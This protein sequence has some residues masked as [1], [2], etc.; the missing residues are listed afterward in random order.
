MESV[1]QSFESR[2]SYDALSSDKGFTLLKQDSSFSFK[3]W[4]L[5]EGDVLRSCL[6]PISITTSKSVI[7]DCNKLLK[8]LSQHFSSTR[9][10]ILNDNSQVKAFTSYYKSAVNKAK[11]QI[12]INRN[13]VKRRCTQ[14]IRTRIESMAAWRLLWSLYHLDDVNKSFR[15]YR[16]S[17]HLSSNLTRSNLTVDYAFLTKFPPLPTDPDE[18]TADDELSS[19]ISDGRNLPVSRCINTL[20]CA[21]QLQ[22][23]FGSEFTP[24]GYCTQMNQ[25][26]LT[27]I[28]SL[29]T[30]ICD[31]D[32]TLEGLYHVGLIAN[33]LDPI[34]SLLA[35][36][37]SKLHI[38][39]HCCINKQRVQSIPQNQLLSEGQKL[40]LKLGTLP[41]TFLNPLESLDLSFSHS[42]SSPDIFF[43][44]CQRRLVH[45][46][47]LVSVKPRSS[48]HEAIGLE[49]FVATGNSQ[50]A[51]G[52]GKFDS[53]FFI[54]E[55]ERSR[56][57]V[58]NALK[59]SHNFSEKSSN[60]TSAREF[61]AAS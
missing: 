56:D 26:V 61:F 60:F 30:F 23:L 33:T 58:A 22:S 49:L 11:A 55:N 21:C 14:L 10:S 16:Q 48:A 53:V 59:P 28:S 50:I 18:L 52:V 39:A 20:S 12:S 44:L 29:S 17:R 7:D 51:G 19:V 2:H 25:V 41:P 13:L 24:R 34:P 40:A 37:S 43:R 9:N 35:V 6:F 54:F 31:P 3:N 4:V 15:G 46:N 45:R 47:S 1:K 38:I 57:F 27:S 32:E 8:N 5:S 42:N 36:T